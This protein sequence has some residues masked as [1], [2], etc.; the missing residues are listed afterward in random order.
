MISGIPKI[1]KADVVQIKSYFSNTFFRPSTVNSAL[2]EI[3]RVF[4][5]NALEALQL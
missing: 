2:L 4:G 1:E 5:A 3:L